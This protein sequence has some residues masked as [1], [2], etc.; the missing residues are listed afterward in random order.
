MR[1]LETE[2]DDETTIEREKRVEVEKEMG[3]KK[4]KFQSSH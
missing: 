4:L 1:Y 3:N 2:E